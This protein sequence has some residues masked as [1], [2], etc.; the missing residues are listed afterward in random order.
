MK[1]SGKNKSRSE[2]LIRGIPFFASLS[3]EE[4]EE[5]RHMLREREFPKGTL[6]LSEEETFQYM[7]VILSGKV[8]V[9]HFSADGKEHI[10][11]IH[12]RGDYFGEMALLDGKTAPATVIAMEDAHLVLIAKE[13]FDRYL[14]NNGKVL[15]QIISMLCVRLRE[16]W[17]MLRILNLPDSEQRVRAVLKMISMQYGVQDTRGTLITFKLTHQ[18]IADYSSVSRETVTRLVNRLVR[19]GEVE[20]LADRNIL[21]KPNFTSC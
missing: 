2:G 7:Y 18:D 6:I 16:S 5:L 17:M 3:A 4:F 15:K 10:L 14:L 9:V 21:L 20:V 12:K 19:D 11:A 1:T 13:D 8:K